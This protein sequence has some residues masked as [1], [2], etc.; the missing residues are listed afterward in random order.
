MF[1]VGDIIQFCIGE[2]KP[3][4]V[5]SVYHDLGVIG[6]ADHGASWIVDVR[7]LKLWVPSNSIERWVSWDVEKRWPHYKAWKDLAERKG[8]T[9]M[10]LLDKYNGIEYLKRL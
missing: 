5:R 9:I 8:I 2:E 10:E 4:K 1:R 6:L 7:N 3:Y